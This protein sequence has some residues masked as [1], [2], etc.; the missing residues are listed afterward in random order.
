MKIEIR[1]IPNAGKTELQKTDGG[2]KA[3]IT[4][5]PVDGKA[6]EALIALLA[7]EFGAAKS[8]IEIIR[9]KTSKNKTVIIHKE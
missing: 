8:D 7:K 6:N 2:Y 9:G 1:V 4:A 5:S 3:R